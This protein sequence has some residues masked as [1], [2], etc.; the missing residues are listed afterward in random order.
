MTEVFNCFS[1]A[2][3]LHSNTDKTDIVLNGVSPDIEEA[4][5]RHT[6]FKKGS[7]P[8]KYL[9]VRISHKRLSKID[10]NVLV[11]K[12]LARIRDWNKKK[13]SYSGRLI[14]VKSVLETIHNYWSQIFFLP[15]GVMD[16]IK[17]LCR[18][19]LWEG[20]ESYTKAPLV[21]WSVLCQGKEYGGLGLTDTHMWNIAAIGK[22]VWWIAIKKDHLRIKW[23]DKIYIKDVP[24]IKYQPTQYSSWAWRKICEVKEKF[25]DAYVQ[26]KWLDTDDA[27]KISKGYEWLTHLTQQ[28]VVWAKVVWNMFNIPRHNFILWLIQRLR[29]L[30]LDRLQ[31]MGIAN[32]GV[33]FLCARENESHHH[34]FHES[35]Y[36]KLCYKQLSSRLQIQL[37]GDI[38]PGQMLL[39]RKFS[40][41]QRL[42]L[43]SLIVAVH[44]GIW[45]VR[46]VYRLDS[47]VMHPVTLIQQIKKES[48]LRIMAVAHGPS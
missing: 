41:L 46:N 45:H 36:A 30:T 48:R 6:G 32:S 34:L 40:G 5:L 3:G 20:H 26:G 31:K 35:S 29:L 4:I 7:L 33:C 47:Y 39:Q 37:V 1:G 25:R 21:A 22:L 19:F 17:A 16:R 43:S 8:F 10:C 24:W 12:M 9:G 14:L 42:V 23:V 13:I 15:I 2:S 11:D 38:S 18:N 44:Y 27:Y 28:K